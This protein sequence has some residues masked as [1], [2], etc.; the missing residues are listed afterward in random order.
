MV[1]DLGTP[2]SGWRIV[3]EGRVRRLDEHGARMQRQRRQSLG[4]GLFEDSARM[5][6]QGRRCLRVFGGGL[7]QHVLGVARCPVSPG[8]RDSSEGAPPA[9]G[10]GRIWKQLL[11]LTFLPARS[12][13]TWSD[14]PHAHCK[15]MLIGC[16]PYPGMWMLDGSQVT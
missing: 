13:G 11:H 10:T 8:S 3:L 6:W 16:C 14:F 4:G 9:A 5:N 7:L 1:A 15:V 12:A 2:A